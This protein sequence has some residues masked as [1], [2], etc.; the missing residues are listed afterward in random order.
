MEEP[1]KVQ[2]GTSLGVNGSVSIVR[3]LLRKL[4]PVPSIQMYVTNTLPSGIGSSLHRLTNPLSS[5]R[6]ISAM[7]DNGL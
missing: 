7:V 4:M 6:L 2:T 3:V 5:E 1:S